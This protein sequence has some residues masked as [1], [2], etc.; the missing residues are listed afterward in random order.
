MDIQNG[1]LFKVSPADISKDGSLVI[2]ETVTEIESNALSN[3]NKLKSLYMPNSLNKIYEKAFC[4]NNKLEFINFGDNIKRIYENSFIGCNNLKTIKIPKN[5]KREFINF[6]F[7]IHKNINKIIKQYDDE[8][9]EY[10]IYQHN[11]AFFIEQRRRKIND[12]EVIYLN[13][14]DF[15]KEAD[16]ET[17]HAYIIKIQNEDFFF[18]FVADKLFYL[19]NREII[20][21]YF[22]TIKHKYVPNCPEKDIICL[23]LESSLKAILH[24]KE[25]LSGRTKK[26]LL[27]YEKQI[28]E[29]VAAIKIFIKKYPNCNTF[30]E[31]QSLDLNELRSVLML[32][33]Q[34]VHYGNLNRL[35]KKRPIFN[36]DMYDITAD[37]YKEIGA[38]P[39]KWL[40]N[41]P[42][43]NR[44]STTKNL[45]T[46]FINSTR[47]LYTPSFTFP[48]TKM[49]EKL[50][51]EKLSKTISKET[52]QRVQIKY[53]GSGHFSK[54][55]LIEF[56]NNDKYI[57]KIYHGDLLNR[58]FN[59]WKHNTE[60]QNSFLLSGKKYYGKSRFR[61]V[62]AG[63]LSSQR[64]ERYSIYKFIEE[65]PAAVKHDCFE[66]LKRYYLYDL[67]NSDN[68]KGS[69][70]TD[71]GAIKITQESWHQPK[72]MIKI[73]NSII[74]HSWDSLYYVLNNYKSYQIKKTIKF[75]EDNINRDVKNINQIQAKID[76]LK[77]KLSL[78]KQ[79]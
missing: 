15:E 7:G 17:T 63:T 64:G 21:N 55:Y 62:S 27:S 75:I 29:I 33:E 52:K 57:W 38:F 50:E 37:G 72:Y 40:K 47:N 2:P 26:E 20:F 58:E 45:R 32:K 10:K 16:L 59:R 25:S 77:N 31:L 46:A 70:I 4:N 19:M 6:F 61:T 14:S 18:L 66:T 76:F 44:S 22:N 65:K 41:I 71:L 67:S 42:V 3:C 9:K 8:T 78:S 24:S 54:T 74:Y 69:T 13:I 68:S 60:I 5:W 73:K 11:G 53:F 39:Y 35:V 79:Y 56:P 49:F 12:I 28:P 51:L 23:V 36:C 1:I 43:F 30:E 48:E 34:D